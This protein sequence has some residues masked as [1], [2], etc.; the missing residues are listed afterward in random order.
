MNLN[1][2]QLLHIGITEVGVYVIGAGPSRLGLS[3][4]MVAPKKAAELVAPNETVP[5]YVGKTP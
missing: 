1:H 2:I 5:W 3:E 4:T